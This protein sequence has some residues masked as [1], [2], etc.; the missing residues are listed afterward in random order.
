MLNKTNPLQPQKDPQQLLNRC[1]LGEKDACMELEQG[2]VGFMLR[3]NS[4]Q[5]NAATQGQGVREMED[6]GLLTPDDIYE[7]EMEEE[8]D[9][10]YLPLKEV[11]SD[12]EWATVEALMQEYPAIVK[13]AEMATKTSDGYVEGEGGPK[14]DMVPARLSDGEFVFSAEAVN[15]IGEDVL[16]NMHE[17]AKR[18]AGSF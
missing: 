9:I 13:L 5:Y 6:G 8:V 12:E 3:G 4:M 11:L 15:V 17:E 7:E 2:R 1:K 16:E 18:M 14:D 10:D